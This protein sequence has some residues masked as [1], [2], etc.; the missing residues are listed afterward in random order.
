VQAMFLRGSDDTLAARE[1][2]QRIT[3]Q[4]RIE[5]KLMNII[6]GDCTLK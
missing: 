6:G 4:C 5:G 3:V 1:K 2:G